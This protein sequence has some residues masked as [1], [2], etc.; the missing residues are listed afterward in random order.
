VLFRHV[1]GNSEHLQAKDAESALLK[2]GQNWANQASLNAVRLDRD[3]GAFH[4]IRVYPP[5]SGREV[6]LS[7]DMF[8]LPRCL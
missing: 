3:E 5:D 6:L 1:A 4:Q 8:V 2:A 7:T